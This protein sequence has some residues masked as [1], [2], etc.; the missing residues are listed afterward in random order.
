MAWQTPNRRGYDNTISFTSYSLINLFIHPRFLKLSTTDILSQTI[1][2]CGELFCALQD[3]QHHPWPLPSRCQQ[4]QPKTFPDFS[5]CPLGKK[6]PLVQNHCIH[7]FKKH[8]RNIHHATGRHCVPMECGTFF[9]KLPRLAREANIK[10]IST[11]ITHFGGKVIFNRSVKVLFKL[12]P[13]QK[14]MHRHGNMRLQGEFL[15]AINIF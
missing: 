2:C 9:L 14:K 13:V 3:V 5:N 12:V 6:S 11:Q 1:I 4:Q 7:S 15:L 8:L 10:H